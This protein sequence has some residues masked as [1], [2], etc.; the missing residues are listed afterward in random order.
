MQSVVDAMVMYEVR[1]RVAY[2]RMNR[3]EK[4]NALSPEMVQALRDAF[5]RFR[6]DATAKVAV[7]SGEG[8][9]F[10]AGA[11]LAY[12]QTMQ[13]FSYDENLQDSNNLK[14]LF[15]EIYLTPKLVIAQ[16]HGYTLAGGCGLASV[17]DL[18]YAGT[19]TKFG[20]TESKLGFLPAIVSVFLVRKLGEA[21]VRELLLTGD[22]IDAEKAVRIGLAHQVFPEETLAQSVTEVAERL[23]REN[24]SQSVLLTKRMIAELQMMNLKEGLEYAAEMNARAREHDDF[25]KG[26]RSF[27]NK[28]KLSW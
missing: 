4:R 20:Y 27:L 21:H 15:L 26:V 25:K 23:C 24:S 13:A 10:C 19:Q 6:Q 9:A 1:N 5:A 16:T 11:D 14:Q 17:C 3:P 12:L 8:K 7:L 18:V 22:Q 2:I 28:E